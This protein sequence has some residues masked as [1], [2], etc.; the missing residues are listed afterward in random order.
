MR[1]W[2]TRIACPS[3]VKTASFLIFFL[4]FGVGAALAQQEHVSG[5]A[6]LKL[7]DLSSVFFRGVDG[8]RLLTIGILFCIFGL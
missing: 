7:P 4:V 2:L 1:T 3:L 8:H 5:E 6:N